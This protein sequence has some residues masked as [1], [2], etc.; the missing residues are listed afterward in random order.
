MIITQESTVISYKKER[1]L[2]T[3]IYNI[4]RPSS[5]HVE[6]GTLTIKQLMSVSISPS[7]IWKC[8]M[9]YFGITPEFLSCVI[10]KNFTCLACNPQIR[11]GVGGKI[12][13]VSDHVRVSSVSETVP[14]TGRSG[15]VR[16]E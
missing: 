12:S 11:L 16:C 1:N 15:A 6:L 7:F 8:I 9:V 10:M 4:P 2:T 5:S 14:N 13:C 3:L